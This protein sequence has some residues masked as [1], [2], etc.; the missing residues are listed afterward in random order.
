MGHTQSELNQRLSARLAEVNQLHQA[1][2]MQGCASGFAARGDHTLFDPAARKMLFL[3]LDARIW[4]VFN[5]DMIGR[6]RLRSRYV[7]AHAGSVHQPP[8]EE[9]YLQFQLR[10][11]RLPSI[12][13]AVTDRRSGEVWAHRLPAIL[14]RACD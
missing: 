12:R 2:F 6:W 13:M 1:N 7:P 8:R 9:F 14:G 3:K 4:W 5:F 10:T 11:E